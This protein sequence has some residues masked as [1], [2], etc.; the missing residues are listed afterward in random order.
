M[1]F[2]E[3]IL[4]K[5]RQFMTSHPFPQQGSK[6]IVGVSGGAD[7]IGLLHILNSLGFHCIVAHCN[8][9]L[10]GNESDQ[11]ELFVNNKAKQM[12][13]PFCSVSFDTVDEAKKQS[14]SIEM[15]AR[16]LRYEWFETLRQN[17]DADAIA[18][19]HHADD[20]VETFFI[21]LI[22]GTGLRGLKG[23]DPVNHHLI[24][25]L[26]CLNRHD[27]ETYCRENQ[28]AYRTDSTNVDP[29]IL[30]NK[31]RHTLIPLFE[32]INP[33]FRQ[34]MQQNMA[35]LADAFSMIAAVENKT[36][37][38]II[39]NNHTR[40]LNIDALLQQTNPHFILFERLRP[41]AFNRATVDLI[42][43]NLNAPSGKQFFSTTH[44]L[45][46]DRNQL[47]LTPV[48][49]L[50]ASTKTIQQPDSTVNIDEQLI[51]YISAPLG[52]RHVT[53]DNNKRQI[54]VDADK[55]NFPLE[56]RH[57]QQGDYFY[58]FGM[59]NKKKLSDYF[60]DIKWNL[61]Q[62]EEAWLLCSDKQIV[63]IIGE[64]PDD[65]F[66]LTNETKSTFKIGIL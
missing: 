9:H 18:I 29:S 56:I 34:T 35:A 1:N 60:I 48:N 13:L 7:S 3:Q 54:Y 4:I 31:I 16:K 58:P 62:K 32:E 28:W 52:D 19:G 30:R 38:W 21:N 57:P 15:A 33:S 10:R 45:I 17:E 44:R 53:F 23:I 37:Q 36:V 14:I 2:S 5:V 26:L 61:L 6:I 50:K 66:K 27:I 22:R 8:F 47:I 55:I 63:W 25:P 24:R 65:R 40:H 46:K 64:R 49:I 11:D 51:I 39:D 20:D 12:N 59:K 42:F 43:K 41:F